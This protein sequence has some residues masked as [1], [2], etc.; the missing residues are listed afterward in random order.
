MAEALPAQLAFIIQATYSID[1]IRVT[2]L[3]R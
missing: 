1:E 2:C 3:T